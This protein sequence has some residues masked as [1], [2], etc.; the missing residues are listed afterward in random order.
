MLICKIVINNDNMQFINTI[1]HKR[2]LY[3]INIL[4]LFVSRKTNIYALLTGDRIVQKGM[5]EAPKKS[6]NT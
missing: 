5:S 3:N 4:H 6:V 1:S 2:T